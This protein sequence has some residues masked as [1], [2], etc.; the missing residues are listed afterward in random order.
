MALLSLTGAPE[1]ALEKDEGDKLAQS[2]ANVARHYPVIGAGVSE[3]VKDHIVLITVVAGIGIKRAQ[4]YNIRKSRER[5]EKARR[6]QEA[7]VVSAAIHTPE[8]D[9]GN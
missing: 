8:Y 3:K 4:A 7:G 2:L 1:F 9:R 6:T 5:A